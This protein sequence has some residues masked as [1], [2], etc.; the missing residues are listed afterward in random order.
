MLIIRKA[1]IEAFDEAARLRFEGKMVEHLAGFLPPLFKAVGEGPLR[2]TI[3]LGITRAGNYGLT[4]QEPV[5]LYLELML[6]FGSYFDTDPQYSWAAES[7]LKMDA[8]SQSERAERLFEKALEYQARVVGPQ[9]DYASRVRRA[10]RFLFEM[11]R[12]QVSEKNFIPD[13]MQ[14]VWRADSPK[15]IYVGSEAIE[16][17]IHH[18]VEVAKSHRLTS[19]DGMRWV[20]IL[21]L[22]FGHG[23][24]NDPLQ[25]WISDALKNTDAGAPET[26]VECLRAETFAW[27]E[28]LLAFQLEAMRS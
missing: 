13:M 19:V 5:R 1:Q 9:D 16:A 18:G 14:E 6:L 24:I 7:L 4:H 27:L 17:L 15:A 28:Q 23:C 25:P 3:R 8:G 10:I 21:M 12:S 2:K 20:V 11:T 22:L 26:R